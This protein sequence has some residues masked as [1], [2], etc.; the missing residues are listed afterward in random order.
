MY[1]LLNKY[2]KLSN[3]GNL[4]ETGMIEFLKDHEF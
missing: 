2:Y 1:I 4:C 3:A